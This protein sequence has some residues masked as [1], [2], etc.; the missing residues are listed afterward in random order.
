MLR[1]ADVSAYSGAYRS[2][3]CAGSQPTV[4]SCLLL[5]RSQQQT[6]SRIERLLAGDG[7]QLMPRG[8]RNHRHPADPE[9]DYGWR[10]SME[11]SRALLSAAP[12][13]A[14][15]FTCA[16]SAL[17]VL[18]DLLARLDRDRQPVF[19][20]GDWARP[21]VVVG[22]V[23]VVGQIEVDQEPPVAEWLGLQVAPRPIRLYPCER[24]GEG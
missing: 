12:H 23:G 3:W 16:C 5:L 1:L 15:C 10:E 9:H 2:K 20:R 21:V 6:A 4:P 19:W 18:V 8:R 14:P 24:V 11:H 7:Y 22:A 17:R 13:C